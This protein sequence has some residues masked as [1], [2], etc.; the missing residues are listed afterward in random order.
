LDKPAVDAILQRQ[1]L[2]PGCRAEELDVP[3]MIA[4]FDA[5]MEWLSS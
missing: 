2:A 1:G 3:A 5:V 4:L